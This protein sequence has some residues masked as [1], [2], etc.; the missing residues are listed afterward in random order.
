MIILGDM[1]ELGEYSA[2][3]HRNIVNL[4]RESSF[5]QVFFVGEIFREAAKGGKEICFND[6]EE[7]R[8]WFSEHP[9]K[10]MT[11]LLKGSRKMK[12]ENLESLF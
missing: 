10:D 8:A 12:L 11:I 5:D 2:E 9:V 7:A 1:M 3:E 4:V 6:V